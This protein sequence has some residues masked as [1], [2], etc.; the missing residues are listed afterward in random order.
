MQLHQHTIVG[1]RR[2][3]LIIDDEELFCRYMAQLIGGLGYQVNT[4]SRLNKA[5]LADLKGSDIIF[6][7]MM[8]PGTD[9]IQ[10]L[11]ILARQEIK[12][13]IVL[14]SGV[15]GDVLT[16]AETIAKSSG[17]RVLAKLVKPFRSAD[18][19]QVLENQ[20]EETARPARHSLSSDINIED[21]VAGLER[22]EF[23]A[24][25]QPIIDLKTSQTFGYEAL[26]RWRSEKFN[27]IMPS[28]FITLAA[29]H[30]ILPRV[31][32][33]ILSQA[34]G[35]A[36]QLQERG[37][38]CKVSVNLGA[39]DLL[40]AGLPERL[41]DMIAAQ[42][43]PPHSLTIELTESSAT[44]NETVMLGV[45]ARLRLKGIELAID[46]FGTS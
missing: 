44:A 29:R 1:T 26:A 37:M 40:D 31:S 7:D 25:L 13:S 30:G 41:A 15:H 42:K 45:L 46:D 22:R 18:V 12:P 14:M 43:L 4:N 17:L 8:M 24:Y 11:D 10:V 36:A 19:R 20:Q 27:L 2:R 21:I 9:G 6:I 35:Y 34:L 32:H 16:T 38:T 23:D 33:Q 5:D 28:R 3:V 39:E